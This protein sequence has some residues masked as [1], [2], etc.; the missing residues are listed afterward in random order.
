MSTDRLTL[1]QCKAAKRYC[2]EM[3]SHKAWFCGCVY[4]QD[5][6]KH[7]VGIEIRTDPSY[8]VHNRFTYATEYEGVPISIVAWDVEKHGERYD[9][10]KQQ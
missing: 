10:E 1:E 6:E 4:Q 7:I 2:W 9:W 8:G 5:V 3:Y